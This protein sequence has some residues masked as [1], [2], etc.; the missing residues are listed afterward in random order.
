MTQ[1]HFAGIRPA[2]ARGAAA[3]AAAGGGVRGAE[4]QAAAA[5][6]PRPRGKRTRPMGGHLLGEAGGRV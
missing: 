3:A 4:Q 6:L 5:W 2:R 1:E